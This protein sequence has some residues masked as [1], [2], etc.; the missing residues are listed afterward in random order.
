MA[1]LALT[2]LASLALG[3]KAIPLADL[4]AAMTGRSDD[5]AVISLVL[6]LR[7]PR[8][9]AGL[10]AGAALGL[11]GAVVQA[12]T[13]NPLAD[14]GILG[15]NAGAACAVALA[16]GL[17][18]ID[19]P[20]LYGFF[21]LA[22]ALVIA[23]VVC[24]LGL[25][26]PLRLILTGMALGAVLAGLTGAIRLT[27][28]QAFNAMMA[29]EIG[30]LTDKSWD[31]IVPLAPFALVGAVLALG[32]GPRLD[33]LALGQETAA[34]L[35]VNLPLTRALA[36]AAVSLLAGGATALVG[37]IGFVG[38]AVPHLARRL[39]GAS[40]PWV[41]GLSAL[42]GP[43]LVLAADVVGRLAAPPA[44]IR[45]A[46]VTAFIGAPLLIHLALRPRLVTL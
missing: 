24:A 20:G 46:I 40:Q 29:W 41:L 4:V 1:L 27:D 9:V 19:Q 26:D 30:S 42:F 3:S 44:E 7:L 45:A 15:V 35:G 21:A 17:A 34:G 6:G 39:V 38:L 12:L 31:V 37:P 33:A 14:P 11:S 32:L 5:P 28:R 13:R 2:A 23:L 36:L 18:G 16:V 25:S 10:V 43:S 22:G 8:T